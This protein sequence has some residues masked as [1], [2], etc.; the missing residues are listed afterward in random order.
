MRIRDP[1][2]MPAGT[3]IESVLGRRTRPIPLQELHGDSIVSPV[4]WQC[5]QVLVV[6]NCP[7]G[8]RFTR[9]TC[10]VPLQ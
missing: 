8:V 9:L 10:P 5:A 3:V 4:P 1:D 2:S 7:N 6:M